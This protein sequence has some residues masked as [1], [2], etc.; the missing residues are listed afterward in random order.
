[1]SLVISIV[2]KIGHVCDQLAQLLALY[3]KSMQLESSFLC[4]ICSFGNILDSLSRIA[5]ITPRHHI[6]ETSR[7]SESLSTSFSPL[8]KSFEASILKGNRDRCLIPSGPKNH[9]C[10][11]Q[12]KSRKLH[13]NFITWSILK[14]LFSGEQIKG[15][16]IF[17]V[18]LIS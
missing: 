12:K 13:Q 8:Q 2:L 15:Q 9:S 14:F 3:S 18:K 4:V 5:Q 17:Q 16:I 1:M 7:Y 11:K 10:L 6:Y